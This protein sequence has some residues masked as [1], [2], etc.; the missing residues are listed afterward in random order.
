MKLLPLELSE[1]ASENHMAR[2]KRRTS[3]GARQK[4]RVKR[5]AKR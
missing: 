2:V 4:A 3:K 5:R 1:M